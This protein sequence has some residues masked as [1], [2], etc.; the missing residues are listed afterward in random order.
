MLGEAQRVQHGA[1]LAEARMLD[2]REIREVN[3]FLRAELAGAAFCP[4][5]G[6]IKP[7][8]ILRGYLQGAPA[9]FESRVGGLERQ[10]AR[11][12][13][14]QLADGRVVPAGGVVDAAGPWAPGGARPRGGGLPGAA[15][16]R[17]GVCG[18]RGL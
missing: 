8:E 12:E 6:T 3:P 2:A 18:A 15:A 17:A 9:R 4:T 7:T 13:A 10:G 1:G 16:G 5:D 14:A 11:I